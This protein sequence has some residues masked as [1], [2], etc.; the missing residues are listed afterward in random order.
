MDFNLAGLL[1][2]VMAAAVNLAP[3]AAPSVVPVDVLVPTA[4]TPVRGEGR[5][6]LLYEL[7]LTNFSGRT[8]YLDG[9]DVLDADAG[10]VL[11]TVSGTQLDEQV[12][13]P[14]RGAAQSPRALGPGEFA[15]IFLEVS[16]P[17]SGP[18]PARLSHRLRFASERP[19]VPA[20]RRVIDGPVVDVSRVPP[21]RLA[22]PL[23][24]GGWLAANAMSNRADHR[25][26]IA[27]VDGKAR[28][29]QRFAIDF[30]QL[31][32]NGRAFVGNPASNGAWTGYGAEVLAVADG[33]VVAVRDGLADNTP[34][35]PPSVPITLDTIG[36]NSVVLDIGDGRYV[37]YGHLQPGAVMVQPGDLVRTGD[38][39][40]RL[41]DSGQSDAPHLHLH[42]A[43]GVSALGGEGLPY[44]FEAYSLEGFVPSL[45][46]LESPEGW[47]DRAAAQVAPRKDE[48]P[49][50]NAVIGFGP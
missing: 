1:A 37:F 20:S 15:L 19:D 7:R 9:L 31:D 43:D 24:G 49:V 2:A 25:R 11:E 38:V 50:E 6:H 34:G 29:A 36:G 5:W 21:L 16:T 46:V 32:V 35:A 33:R 48:L 44:V 27:V 22:R 41:G 39:V 3:P 14:G 10:A 12:V 4:P 8:M 40:G 13:H 30:V 26:T 45:G 18:P 17:A 47:K 28:I 23:K 42:V